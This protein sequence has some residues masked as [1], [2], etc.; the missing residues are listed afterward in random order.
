MFKRIT[1]AIIFCIGLLP[2]MAGAVVVTVDGKQWDVTATQSQ[3]Y[4]DF[5]TTSQ[6][7]PW[8]GDTFGDTA[9]AFALAAVQAGIEFP[10][11]T[12][13]SVDLGSSLT[14][15]FV[16]D[17]S[18]PNKADLVHARDTTGSSFDFSLVDLGGVDTS[19]SSFWAVAEEVSVPVPVPLAL[20]IAGLVGFGFTNEKFSQVKQ[21]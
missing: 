9:K 10:N 3:P 2:A 11:D 14:P 4:S 6:A 19:V 8:Y 12:F 18:D 1:L 16:Y 7:Q 20:L 21:V 15:L 13:L 17:S 5:A